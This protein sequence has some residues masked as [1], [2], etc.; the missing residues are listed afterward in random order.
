MRYVTAKVSKKA[1]HHN[2]QQIRKITP[3]S[4]I[5][6][7][8]KANAYGHGLIDVS[9][10]LQNDVDAF[11]VACIDEAL[12]LRQAGILTNIVLM[13]GIFREDELPLVQ[14]HNLTMVVHHWQ[15]IKAIQ[16]YTVPTPV[17]FKV[18][19]KINT[20]MNRLG[21]QPDAFDAAWQALSQLPHVECI[22]FMT[23]FAQADEKDNETTKN[24][25]EQFYKIVGDRP[26][27][28][29]L[30]NSA[31]IL[32]WPDAHGDW[33]RPGL[34]LYGAS[35]FKAPWGHDL[36]LIPAM[37]LHSE[38]ISIR[39]ITEG[40]KV[41]YGGTWKNLRKSSTIGI[42]AVG[43]GDGYPWH[44]QNNTP[45]L[46]NNIRCPLVGRVSMDMLAVDITDQPSVEVGT[47]VILWGEGLAIEEVAQHAGTIPWELF[48]RFTER[49][50]VSI[51]G[52]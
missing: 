26:G 37:S 30:A 18:W 11:G 44:A 8:V 6:A 21:F 25:I 48:C 4:K 13:E 22:G 17:R 38:I 3:H 14:A 29:S 42:V 31:G 9:K 50:T 45:V 7:M 52:D 41:G 19:I 47:P 20:G 49:V 46:V 33:V 12:R 15:Q 16:N 32:A 2:L 43:Y 40:E 24:Q 34:I 36:N 28:R 35:P 1:L 23:H 51:V 5:M 10:T 27:L 39:T